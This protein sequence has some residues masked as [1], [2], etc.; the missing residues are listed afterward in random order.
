MK[1]R[2]QAALQPT[3]RS[4]ALHTTTSRKRKVKEEKWL[5]ETNFRCISRNAA[6]AGTCCQGT[7][8][9]WKQQPGHRRSVPRHHARWS[10][11]ELPVPHAGTWPQA[12]GPDPPR[13]FP[14]AAPGNEFKTR[15]GGSPRMNHHCRDQSASGAGLR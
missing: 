8:F 9:P 12:V 15:H 3:T 5:C 10:S 6:R 7:A 4:V 14:P 13:Q 1:W 11:A 2:F